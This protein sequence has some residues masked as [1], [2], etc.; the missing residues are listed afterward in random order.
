MSH[1]LYFAHVGLKRSF[2]KPFAVARHAGVGDKGVFGKLGI[3]LLQHGLYGFYRITL[4]AP[5]EGV[6]K[7]VVFINQRGLCGG[8][9]C[10]DSQVH[11]ISGLLYIFSSYGMLTVSCKEPVVLLPGHE[12][13]LYV[14]GIGKL[15][16][17]GIVKL[18]C[19]S[20]KAYLVA[21]F[22]KHG[23]ADCNEIS[24]ILR[25]YNVLVLKLQS[26]YKSLSKL[27]QKR[28]RSAQK[29]HLPP[30]GVSA[31]Q[32]AY[33]LVDDSLKNGRSKIRH[34]SSVVYE[35]LDVGLCEYAAPCGYRIY[36]LV[37]FGRLV[38]SSRVGVK[39]Y[40]HLVYERTGTAC[41]GSVHSLLDGCA[42]ECN[43]RVL[44]SQLYGYVRLRNESLHGAAA[45][46]NLLLK[47]NSQNR[48]KGKPAR[49]GDN[50][51]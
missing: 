7:V 44:S 18:V 32:S 5:V 20:L 41:A 15:A 6:E 14:L 16:L 43:L 23:R 33:G 31:G 42:V 13:R 30:Y 19:E 34:R 10:V 11:L 29:S 47:R 45:G 35:G 9:T 4:V 36:H 24:G 49:S 12:Q 39:E 50:R 40:C 17:I 25:E 27:R 2:N 22:G 51:L 46:Y 21:L 48:C 3:K 37:A 28:Q 38:K 1:C 8:R 26:F